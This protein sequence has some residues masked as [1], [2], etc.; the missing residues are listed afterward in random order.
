MATL[1]KTDR[2]GTK[3]YEGMVTCDRCGGRG[4]ADAWQW[5]GWTCYKCGGTGKILGKWKEYTPEY[6]AK[7]EAKRQ[8]KIAAWKEEQAKYEAERDAREA[9]IRAEREAREAEEAARRAISQ[10]V[11]TIGEKIN[12]TVKFERVAS[13]EIPAYGGGWG[14]MQT[15]R[16]YTFADENGNKFIWKTTSWLKSDKD[17]DFEEGSTITIKGTIKAFGEYKGEKQTELQRVKVC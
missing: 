7:L 16:I 11:G 2:N 9:Q 17:E 4:G 8:A 12:I 6:E 15:M 13:F 10:Y 1:I 14:R 3:Y 5:T